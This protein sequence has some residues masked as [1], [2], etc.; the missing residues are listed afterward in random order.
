MLIHA[1]VQVNRRKTSLEKNL[2]RVSVKSKPANCH[3]TKTTFNIIWSSILPVPAFYIYIICKLNDS[4]VPN[5][6]ECY[7][8]IFLEIWINNLKSF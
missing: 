7:V 6:F 8:Q 4:V 5:D 1:K 3:D 2:S